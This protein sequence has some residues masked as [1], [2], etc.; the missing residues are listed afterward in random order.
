MPFRCSRA[1]VLIALA[2]TNRQLASGLRASLLTVKLT[3]QAVEALK[4]LRARQN[5]E[6]L[7]PGSLWE[8]GAWCSPI[9]L[10]NH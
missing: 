10:R 3:A 4:G 6:R 7:R 1:P 9:R 2:K 8:D 5:E